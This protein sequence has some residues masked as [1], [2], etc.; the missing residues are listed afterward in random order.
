LNI[1]PVCPIFVPANKLDWVPK[2]LASNA[3]CIIFD[4]EDSVLSD[5][6]ESSRNELYDYLKVN[7]LDISVLVRINPL[8]SDV[9]KADLALFSE[10][11][12]IYDAL[13]LPK[14]EEPSVLANLPKVNIVLLIETPLAIKNLPLLAESKQAVGV[15][16]GGADLSASLGSDMSW[17]S[18]L[19]HRSLI[20]LEGSINNLFTIDS[21]FMSISSLDELKQE[22]LLSSKMGF[23]GKAAIHPSQI[24]AILEAFLPTENEIEEAKEVLIAFS[25][26]SQA[27]V[28]LKGKMI[29]LPVVKAMKKRLRLA[30]IDPDDFR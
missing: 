14:I 25:N 1:S 11:T 21:P 2:I 17:D 20:V 13:M 18:L 3:D 8:D 23:N 7:K 15:A 4:L 19:F 10:N 30:G 22:S 5:Q 12:E 27:A 28:A 16:L 9:G 24:E 6:K 26:A 29:D